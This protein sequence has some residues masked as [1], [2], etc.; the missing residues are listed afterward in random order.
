MKRIL[1]L[2][3]GTAGSIVANEL[4]RELRAEIARSVLK[5]RFNY[6]SGKRDTGT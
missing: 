1:I 6:K 5:H 2:G 3:G 4:A